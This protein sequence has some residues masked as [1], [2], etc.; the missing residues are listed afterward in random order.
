MSADNDSQ[1]KGEIILFQSND[2]QTKIQ[3]RFEERS[4][5]LTQAAIAELFQTTPQNI[6]LHLK[7]IYEEGE[8]V[9][10]ATCKEYLQVRQ[11][12][13][14]QIS[15]QLKHY[16]LEAILAVGYRVRSSR[17]TQFRQ[18]ATAQLQELLVKGFVMNDDRLK[19]GKSI[20]QD[21]FDELLLRIRDIRAS[22]RRFYQKITDIYATSIDY[23][24]RAEVTQEFY[25]TVQNK[26]HW[27]IH[28]KTAAEV[29]KFRADASKKNMGLT[30][31]KNSPD[32]PIR[33]QDVSVAKNYLSE[34][35]LAALNRT[36]VMYLDYAEDQALSRKPMY[37]ADWIK[38]LDG[39]LQFNEKN[40]LTNAGK[41]SQKMALEHAESEFNKYENQLCQ[42]ESSQSSSDFDKLAK[43]LTSKKS[44]KN[45]KS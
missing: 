41:I 25:A 28:G 29:I 16:N 14:R 26:L 30:T 11:E 12:G 31:W 38:K 15:R 22:E 34:E 37:M 6:T 13:K 33:K 23:D 18:W 32:G 5:W 17:G 42:I 20:G 45:L 9:E 2:G 3:V 8:L 39:F 44:K 43:K 35:E 19:E 4:V 21:Y 7:S 36:V 27:A 40:I 24:G 10:E 1:A